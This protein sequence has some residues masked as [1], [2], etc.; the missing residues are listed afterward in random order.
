MRRFFFLFFLLVCFSVPALATSECQ[1]TLRELG[2]GKTVLQVEGKELFVKGSREDHDMSWDATLGRHLEDKITFD[3]LTEYHKLVYELMANTTP[4]ARWYKSPVAKDVFN[5]HSMGKFVSARK[6]KHGG[7]IVELEARFF[8]QDGLPIWWGMKEPSKFN[9]EYSPLDNFL[10]M[11]KVVLDYLGFKFDPARPERMELPDFVEI[12]NAVSKLNEVLV[13]QGKQPI[14]NYYKTGIDDP[15]HVSIFL[16]RFAEKGN[17]KFIREDL[18][19]ENPNGFHDSNVH[20][21]VDFP[22]SA[23]KYLGTLIRTFFKIEE[24]ITKSDKY[25]EAEKKDLR[26][27]RFVTKNVLA[28]ILDNAFVGGVV[29]TDYIGLRISATTIKNVGSGQRVITILENLKLTSLAISLGSSHLVTNLMANIL[30]GKKDVIDQ[31]AALPN[32]TKR[33]KTALE[34]FKE[35][36]WS[37]PQ[38]RKFD[39]DVGLIGGKIEGGRMNLWD[40]IQAER[41]DKVASP[42]YNY[43]HALAK[44]FAQE[45]RRI[46]QEIREA[47]EALNN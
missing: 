30:D 47:I 33:T 35:N 40:F 14:V 8:T 36:S 18:N 45:S 9:W 23:K 32:I 43:D 20:T 6:G 3:L 15:Y 2:N 12:T 38:R 19:E 31:L 44:M 13:A 27:L 25:T 5:N 17:E 1:V 21:A 24:V 16:K 4:T 26:K 39:Q 10:M 34:S 41:T 29:A 7:N 42:R 22:H 46:K 11:D 37:Y 28:A